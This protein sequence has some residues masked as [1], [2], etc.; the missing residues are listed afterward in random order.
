MHTCMG[1]GCI[2]YTH[3]CI[4]GGGGVHHI[5]AYMYRGGGGG[6]SYTCIHVLGGGGVHHIHAYMY[7]GGA[8]YTCIQLDPMHVLVHM[9]SF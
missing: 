5:H 7:G 4:G 9:N 3:T 6:A 1:G 8:S 2:I